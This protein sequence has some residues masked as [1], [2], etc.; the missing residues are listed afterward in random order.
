[1]ECRVGWDRALGQEGDTLDLGM[2]SAILYLLQPLLGP[3]L[4]SEETH[5]IHEYEMNTQMA[6]SRRPDLGVHLHTSVVEGGEDTRREEALGEVDHQTTTGA[7]RHKVTL[8]T[9]LV[10]AISESVRVLRRVGLWVKQWDEGTEDRR[11]GMQMNTMEHHRDQGIPMIT[12]GSSRRRRTGPLE[13]MVD[14]R[15]LDRLLRPVLEG[16][17]RR[18]HHPLLAIK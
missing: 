6:L 7:S 8:A 5:Q 16:G 10:Q 9:V 13:V 17:N 15:H 4:D 18:V 2:N 1:M 3:L 14:D 11:Q 12:V